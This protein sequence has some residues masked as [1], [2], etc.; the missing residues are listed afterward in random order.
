MHWKLLPIL[1]TTLVAT[2]GAQNQASA[3]PAAS[4]G[5]LELIP[6]Q[7]DGA[8]FY[9][10]APTK[11]PKVDREALIGAAC[12]KAKAEGKLVLWYVHRI[13]EKKL[14]GRQMYRAPVLDV[15]M[16]QVVFA[17]PDV[18]SMASEAFVPVR[19]MLDEP[20]AQRFD[21]RPLAFVEPAVLFLDG[22]GKVVHFV[23]RFRT[24][25]A[26]WFADLMARLLE[27][28]QV[29][30]KA[31]TPQA[32]RRLGLWRPA[33]AV[34]QAK[35]DKSA[36]EWLE[37]A[38]L[39]RLLRQPEAALQSLDQADA[40][41]SAKA[42]PDKPRRGPA[43]A[44][45]GSIAFDI[46]CERGLLL[47]MSG[48]P[49]EA[50]PYL[51]FAWRGDGARTAE[52]GYWSAL[53]ALHL[54]DET[55]AMRRFGLVAERFADTPFGKRAR[56]NVQ[57]GPD[58]R[59]IGAAFTGFES[60]RYLPESAYQGMPKDT[61]WNGPALAPK[62]MALQA[63]QFLLAQQHDD[64]G[65]TDARYAY[66]PSSEITPNVWVAV[67]GIALSA[68]WEYRSMFPELQARIDLAL[69]RGEAFAFDPKRLNRGANE[70]CYSDAYRLMYLGRRARDASGD[71]KQKWIG[72]MNELVQQA[73]ARQKASG[74]WAHEY[75]NAFATGA[76]LQELV[77]ARASGA[78]VPTEVTDKGA[79]A[80]ISARFKTGTFA[81]GGAAGEGRGTPLKD[82]VG[83][84]PVCEGTLLQL[85]RSDLDKLR[86]AMNNFWEF[87][88]N[89]EG[90]RRNDFH[91]D[92]ELGGF[93]FFHSVFHASEAVLLLPEEERAA[94]WA[95]FTALLQ[96]I[97]EM[98][99]SFLD[100]HE[101]GRSYGTAMA[102]LTLRNAARF[103]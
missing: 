86:F 77:A 68:L 96:D 71:A 78:T 19:C 83:R 50:Q 11:P 1:L 81:Y 20:L 61:T 3:H 12:A 6:W 38:Q 89:L 33:L 60:I 100:S 49:L 18:A 84:M 23:E 46:A 91:S 90:V 74:F 47:A 67:T 36:A 62:A 88:K 103:E 44:A 92:G 52:A 55:F 95:K 59:P 73:Q 2:V 39:Q 43:R 17:D 40:T 51:E 63:L 45:A 25:H 15:Y 53:D 98:D 26:Q 32:M 102:L 101:L 41:A 56:A 14:G 80:L 9:D 24:F 70:D 79:A 75:E 93:F 13:E 31:D 64:G 58:D 4:L 16:Q 10:H 27:Q 76:V 5:L 66:W 34:L 8:D 85:G 54:G 22:D 82:A 97:P 42:D 94:H 30:R 21:L 69:Q 7:R 65:F 99:G 48:R 29:P 72:R 57:L 37:L 35:A 87:M 28:H